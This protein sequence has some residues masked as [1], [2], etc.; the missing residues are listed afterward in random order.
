[1]GFRANG[2]RILLVAVVAATTLGG[3]SP[4]LLNFATVPSVH[5]LRGDGFGFKL[6]VEPLV[7][8]A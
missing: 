8:G 3:L 6:S 7:V 5:G 4:S 1:M 2:I